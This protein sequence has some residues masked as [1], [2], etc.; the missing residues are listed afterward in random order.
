MLSSS[1]L[2]FLQGLDSPSAA[3]LHAQFE[4]D[5]CACLEASGLQT[6]KNAKECSVDYIYTPGPPV[7]EAAN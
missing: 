2:E 5:L 3:A 7:V 1:P 6:Y 4:K